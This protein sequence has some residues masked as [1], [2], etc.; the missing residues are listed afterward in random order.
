MPD[1]GPYDAFTAG[2]GPMAAALVIGL[3][4]VALIGLTVVAVKW[5][6]P[7]LIGFF[8]KTAK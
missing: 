1:P 3:S 7:Q 8:K 2:L 4:A 6:I 5:G